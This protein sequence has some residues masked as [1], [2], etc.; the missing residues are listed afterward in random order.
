MASQT[1]TTRPAP[2]DAEAST[3]STNDAGILR[4]GCRSIAAGMTRSELRPTPAFLGVTV[5]LTVL[6][7]GRSKFFTFSS[8]MSTAVMQVASVV[9]VNTSGRGRSRRPKSRTA[10]RVAR[11]PARAG[12]GPTRTTCGW[13]ALPTAARRRF[14]RKRDGA[15]RRS[16]DS[17]A[18]P[19]P[20]S[21]APSR[22]LNGADVVVRRTDPTS[23]AV[24]RL[25]RVSAPRL[26]E[27]VDAYR[28]EARAGG[29]SPTQP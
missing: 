8:G 9:R 17:S 6:L 2:F 27:R 1:A 21:S 18:R 22:A 7:S 26:P 16:W 13:A 15:S 19:N 20:T 28:A 4:V 14:S 10:S 5:T 3:R 12:P 23:G 11:K 24:R 25:V 29:A